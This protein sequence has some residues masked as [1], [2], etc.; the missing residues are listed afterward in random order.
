M[1]EDLKMR[2]TPRRSAT[3]LSFSA[4]RIRSGSASTTD[5]P[6]M[7]NR[8]VAPQSIPAMDTWLALTGCHVLPG[9]PADRTRGRPARLPEVDVEDLLVVAAGE[10][11]PVEG[12]AG[13]RGP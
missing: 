12:P 13:G 6:A 1:K 9:A 2:G 11:V 7:R 3:F 5:G 4:V 8:S 10:V